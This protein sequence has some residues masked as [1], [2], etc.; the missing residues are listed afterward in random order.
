MYVCCWLASLHLGVS[1][2]KD[3]EGEGEQWGNHGA[4]GDKCKPSVDFPYSNKK[5][6]YGVG[7][8]R[9]HSILLLTSRIVFISYSVSKLKNILQESHNVEY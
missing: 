6:L 7:G 1:L 9:S 2:E 3:L 5:N 4:N 8:G